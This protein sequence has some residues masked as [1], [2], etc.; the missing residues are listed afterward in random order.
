MKREFSAK[1]NK[2]EELFYLAETLLAFEDKT[3]KSIKPKNYYLFYQGIC[4]N[5]FIF[6]QICNEKKSVEIHHIDKN[7]ENNSKDNLLFICK[8]C[9]VRLHYFNCQDY[10]KAYF[11][12]NTIGLGRPP[13]IPE[14]NK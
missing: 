2:Q 13:E 14:L 3:T 6:C 11:W 7:R 8:K 1:F 4:R 12:N 10:D 5:N 9:H